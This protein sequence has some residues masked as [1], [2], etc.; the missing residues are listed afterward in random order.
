MKYQLLGNT[1]LSVSKLSYGASPLGGVFG[2]ISERDGIDTVHKAID[3]GINLID[4]S[5]YYGNT[6]AETVLG[7]ALETV[8]RDRYILSSKAG[9]YGADFADFDFSASRI[10]ASLQESL[11]RLKTDYLDIF[12]LHDIEFAS[13]EQI[14]EE[15]LPTLHALKQEG[16]VRFIGVTG[17]PIHI[18]EETL[19]SGL[20]ID[21]ILTYCRYALHDTSLTNFLP[22]LINKGVG[23]INASPTAMGVLTERGAPS[24]HPGSPAFIDASKKAVTLCKKAGTDITQVAMQ[25]AT[26]HPNIASTLVGTANPNNI[27]KNIQWIEQPLDLNLV[28]EIQALFSD[29]DCTWPS[30]YPE[31]Q[32]PV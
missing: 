13:L 3:S 30:G 7:K 24:W 14:Y 17:Y 10:R 19:K 31:N 12:L 15:A 25:F 20:A 21:V 27:V 4:V 26:A 9:R 5:P 28:K 2:N 8:P 29:I 23:V 11:T 22:E 32:D 18:F 1:G 6:V 16:A